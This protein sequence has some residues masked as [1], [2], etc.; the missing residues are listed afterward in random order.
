ML[1]ENEFSSIKGRSLLNDVST[2]DAAYLALLLCT[3][4]SNITMQC[5]L[6]I[7]V[8]RSAHKRSFAANI[9]KI[10]FDM[11]DFEENDR[12]SFYRPDRSTM[13]N[14]L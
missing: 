14:V 13:E 12:T 8:H 10:A 11:P 7:W 6:T 4:D 2:P 5:T 3:D 9:L 1:K